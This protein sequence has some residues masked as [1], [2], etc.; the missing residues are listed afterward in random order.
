M[1]NEGLFA[2]CLNRKPDGRPYADAPGVYSQGAYAEYLRIRPDLTYLVS[3]ATS[4]DVATLLEPLSFAFRCVN[5]AVERDGTAGKRVVVTGGGIIAML[6]CEVLKSKGVEYVA[7]TEV[8]PLRIKHAREHGAVDE[9]FDPTNEDDMKKLAA[10]AGRGFDVSY[11]CSGKG[12]ALELL[13]KLTRRTGTI[14][15]AG[16]SFAPISISTLLPVMKE[17]SIV[18][19]YGSPGKTFDEA[20]ELAG[21][22]ND[23]LEKHITYPNVTLEGAQKALEELLA[24]ETNA[25]K[26]VIDPHLREE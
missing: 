22:I 13:F 15:L 12:Q 6:V 24:G 10:E 7:L 25:I 19:A 16:I 21:K 1:C 20:L 8:N 23:R 9:V 11:E 5:R 17:L 2:N 26:L 18:T 3:D 4:S 14:L